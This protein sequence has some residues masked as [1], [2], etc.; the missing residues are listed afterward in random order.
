VK[1]ISVLLE[2]ASPSLLG[3]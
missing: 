1:Q 2:C 3:S